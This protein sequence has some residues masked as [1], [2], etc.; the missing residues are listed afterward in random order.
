MTSFKSYKIQMEAKLVPELRMSKSLRVLFHAK[1]YN[2]EAKLI[3]IY[4]I[5]FLSLSGI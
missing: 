2:L 4:P 1:K 5:I 3:N